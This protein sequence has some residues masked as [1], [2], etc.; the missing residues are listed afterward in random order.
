ML[1]EADRTPVRIFRARVLWAPETS[2]VHRRLK[3]SSEW[4]VFFLPGKA[5][6]AEHV[7]KR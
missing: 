5:G 2:R 3:S 7:D 1:P 6:P 4:T